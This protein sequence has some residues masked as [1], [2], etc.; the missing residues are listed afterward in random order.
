MSDI[1]N[2]IRNLYNSYRICGMYN[3]SIIQ[4]K[5]L[6]IIFIEG[7]YWPEYSFN[8]NPKLFSEIEIVKN[9][10]RKH[11]IS[12]NFLVFSNN[13][14]LKTIFDK[15]NFKTKDIWYIM[16]LKK[17][18]LF[19]YDKIHNSNINIKLLKKDELSLWNDYIGLD[20][21]FVE[22][23]YDN[24]FDFYVLMIDDFVISTSLFHV[25]NNEASIYMVGTKKEYRNKGFASILMKNNINNYIKDNI[26]T[27]YLQSTEIGEKLYSSLGFENV[28]KA[29]IY[30]II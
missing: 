6:E 27:F 20:H 18:K 21:N 4:N 29:W 3:N 24:N 12:N 23:L 5:H 26:N 11:I 17:Y 14:S 16:N 22:F 30:N 9:Q 19:F 2:N 25:I 1:K 28:G 15:N 8:L 10:I 7:N 13:M